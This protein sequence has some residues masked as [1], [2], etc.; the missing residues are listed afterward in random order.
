V[1]LVAASLSGVAVF[2]ARLAR[3]ATASAADC[4]DG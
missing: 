1:L 4:L 2:C 3:L